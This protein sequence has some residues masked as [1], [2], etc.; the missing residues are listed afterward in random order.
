[1]RKIMDLE[2][3]A[4]V[5]A[6]AAILRNGPDQAMNEFNGWSADGGA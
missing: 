3:A 6:A 1:M 4:S 2:V 5:K